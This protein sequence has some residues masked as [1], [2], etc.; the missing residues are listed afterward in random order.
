MKKSLLALLLAVLP[1]AALPAEPL[2]KVEQGQLRGKAEGALSVYRGVPFA[3]APTGN[4]R[5][6]A[7]QSAMPWTGIRTA[8][9]FAPQCM[10]GAGGAGMS[11][12]CLFLNVW[13]PAKSARERVPVM[14]WIYGGGFSGGST[15][16]PNTS[17]EVLAG[18][19][20]VVVSIAYRVGPLGFLAHPELSAESAQKASGNYGLLDMVA[21]LQW[22]RRNIA[23][24]GGDPSRVTIFG[25]SAGAIAV[26]QLCASPLAKGLFAGAISES[27]GSFA[28][29][30]PTGQ[31]GENM[32]SLADAERQ[33]VAIARSAG[34]SSLAALRALPAPQVLAA[35]RGNGVSWP[36]VDGWVLPSDQYPLYE[37]RRFNDVPVL[38]GYNSDEG[39]S[40]PREANSADFI[41]NTHRRYGAFAD[42]MLAAYPPGNGA[43]PRTARNMVRDASFGW[44]SWTWAKL[45]SRHGK[46][47]AWLYFFNQHPLAAAGSPQADSG[48]THGR[49]IAYVFGQLQT[50][51]N[52]TPTAADRLV[53]DAMATYW[54][55]FAKRG[56]PNG[57]GVPMWPAFSSSNQQAMHFEGEARVGAVPDETGLKVLDDYFAWRRTPAGSRAAAEQDATPATTNVPGATA[58]RVMP[59][60]SIVLELAAPAARTVAVDI[61]GRSIPLQRSSEGPWRVTTPSQPAGLHYYQFVVDGLRV[62][63]PGS[64]TFFGNSVEISGIEVPDDADLHLARDVPHGEVRI[65]PYLSKVTGQWRRAF[66][67]TPPGYDS[68]LQTRYPVLYLQHGS[69]EDETAWT[70]QGQANF[71]LD[72]LI[73]EGKAVPMIVVMDNSYAAR[74]AGGGPVAPPSVGLKMDAAV[75]SEVLV[76]DVI[77]MIDGSLR[78][79]ADRAHR[80]LNGLGMN[81]VDAAAPLKAL[82]SD[83]VKYSFQSSPAPDWSRSRRELRDYAALLFKQER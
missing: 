68:Q 35:A 5:W 52:E 4:L 65:R 23:A 82:V 48:A 55:N 42:R 71:I 32:R 14:V 15:A 66:I 28:A 73:A 38:V 37:A 49:E 76:R 75:F 39:A 61:N 31:P 50:L 59:D 41:T 45:H 44:Q 17:G 43:L 30:R 34:V 13:T 2:A 40:F 69:G 46:S 77:P 8:T 80:A 6:R 72:N 26:S 9:E 29:P 24:F 20:V 12:D 22:I 56:D 54:T 79:Q 11:E 36:V 64:R 51:R 47:K 18:K 53:S 67:Y 33:G 81:P 78:T 16:S 63:D 25:E 7:P 1:V 70:S 3:A 58:P 19:G 74:P 60:R 57:K 10:Q 21:A 83:T 27:G 62:N